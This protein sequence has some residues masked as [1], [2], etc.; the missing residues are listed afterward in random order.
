MA[1]ERRVTLRDIA[2]RLGISHA[3][4]SLALRNHPNISEGRKEEVR[5]TALEMGYRPDPA[6]ASLIAYRR[7]RTAQPIRA[8]IAWVN[9]VEHAGEIRQYREFEAYWKGATETAEHFGYRL[10][11]VRWPHDCSPERF[12]EIISTRGIRGL[13]IP[14]HLSQPDWGS[15]RWE[16]FSVVRFGL[17]V[18]NPDS[19][20]VTSDQ[21][22]MVMLALEKM[23]AYGYRRIGFVL[24]EDFD[25]KVGCTFSAGY[26]VSQNILRLEPKIPPLFTSERTLKDA[27]AQAFREFKSWFRAHRPDALLTAAPLALEFLEKM[28]LRIPDDIAVAGT[29][30]TDVPVSAGID[31]NSEEIGRVA[32]ETL[33]SLINANDVGRPT[34]PRRILVTGSWLDGASLPRKTA[35]PLSAAV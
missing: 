17:S 32:V 6:L 21:M 19:H 27:P 31:Q 30:V 23:H 35:A 33:I 14:P 12:E 26:L 29:S 34:S 18:R 22:R 20:V 8:S 25:L 16:N 24:P 11:E 10:D 15:F 3:T 13:L 1:I 2:H 5:R 28:G 4:V 7:G 9:Q